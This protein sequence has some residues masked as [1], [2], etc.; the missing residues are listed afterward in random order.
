MTFYMIKETSDGDKVR[1]YEFEK[2][3]VGINV[4]VFVYIKIR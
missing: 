2:R 1:I 3:L 4:A